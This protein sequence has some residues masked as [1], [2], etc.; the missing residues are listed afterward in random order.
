MFKNVPHKINIKINNLIEEY[1]LEASTIK[2][3]GKYTIAGLLCNGIPCVYD[4][5]NIIANC[6][7]TTNKYKKYLD[8][9]EIN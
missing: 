2:V 4:S 1:T 5:N 9:L 8:T 7:W 3:S 6:D